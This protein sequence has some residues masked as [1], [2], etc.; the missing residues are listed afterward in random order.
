MTPPTLPDLT[1]LEG[2]D[3]LDVVENE[4]GRLSGTQ[5]RL[6]LNGLA[7]E[8]VLGSLVMVPIVVVQMTRGNGIFF[9]IVAALATIWWACGLFTRALDVLEGRVSVID[10]DALAQDDDDSEGASYWIEIGESRLPTSG[11]VR[12]QFKSGG[13]YRIYYLPR[14]KNVVSAHALAE[15]RPLP[16]APARRLRLFGITIGEG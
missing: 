7:A 3:L 4:A 1:G 16:E 6:L 5:R 11:K 9:G 15:W 10:G 13:P 8:S 2:F 12:A 14:A